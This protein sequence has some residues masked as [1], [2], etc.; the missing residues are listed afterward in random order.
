MVEVCADADMIDTGGLANVI[1]VI[2][3]IRKG[4]M[5]ISQWQDA[6]ETNVPARVLW[7]LQTID[8]NILILTNG[9]EGSR[10]PARRTMDQSPF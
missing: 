2:G 6:M 5:T 9:N 4:E 10:A 1:D 8:F 7:Q 3:N